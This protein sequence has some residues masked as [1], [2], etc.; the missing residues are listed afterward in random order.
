[1][2]IILRVNGKF[3]GPGGDVQCEPWCSP[4]KYITLIL[5]GI[6]E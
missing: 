4:E 5:N 3:E 6:K 1:M 2:D